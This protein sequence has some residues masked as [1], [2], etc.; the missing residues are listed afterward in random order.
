MKKDESL[1]R[2]T[3]AGEGHA[4]S[5][6]EKDES[7]VE[8]SLVDDL[9]IAE[10]SKESEQHVDIQGPGSFRIKMIRASGFTAHCEGSITVSR[11]D[12][13]AILWEKSNWRSDKQGVDE[14]FKV[15]VEQK[16]QLCIKFRCRHFASTFMKRGS[17]AVRVKIV[18]LVGK[19]AKPRMLPAGG[20]SCALQE[21]ISRARSTSTN[22]GVAD[23]WPMIP[24][25]MAADASRGEAAADFVIALQG[26]CQSPRFGARDSPYLAPSKEPTSTFGQAP[27]FKKGS[28]VKVLRRFLG[29]SEDNERRELPEGLTGVV[30]EV[31][32]DGDLYIVFNEDGS[33]GIFCQWVFKHNALNLEI[34]KDTSD[35]DGIGLNFNPD[36]TPQ[37]PSSVSA[38]MGKTF[39]QVTFAVPGLGDSPATPATDAK[40]ATLMASVSTMGSSMLE[41]SGECTIPQFGDSSASVKPPSERT[42]SYI[43]SSTMSLPYASASQANDES[44][45]R[46]VVSGSLTEESHE[47]S[48][49]SDAPSTCSMRFHPVTGAPMPGS[50]GTYEGGTLVNVLVPA[51][52]NSGGDDSTAATTPSNAPKQETKDADGLLYQPSQQPV[53]RDSGLPYVPPDPNAPLVLSGNSATS[54]GRGCCLVRCFFS[55]PARA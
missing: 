18:Q 9:F 10:G 12:T 31:D 51:A 43:Q 33:N 5:V 3:S 17:S 20:P 19:N 40:L 32:S 50:L 45:Q 38:S 16:C 22:S 11:R 29:D 23:A 2:P 48:I 26:N 1:S 21:A 53:S 52:I 25:D 42:A 4:S 6:S 36:L 39:S 46:S 14:I 27:V 24:N 55:G 41:S 13:G 8:I 34:R 28:S 35:N 54:R 49:A 47:G 7:M 15:D 37:L 44:F 30:G